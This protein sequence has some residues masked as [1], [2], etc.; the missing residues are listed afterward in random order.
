MLAT[1]HCGREAQRQVAPWAVQHRGRANFRRP[2]R[3]PGEL[4]ASHERDPERFAQVAASYGIEIV[5][6]SPTLD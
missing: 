3:V 5:G 2:S 1:N 4:G 6:P